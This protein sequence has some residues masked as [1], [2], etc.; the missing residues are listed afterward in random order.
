MQISND[1]GLSG[2]IVKK[3]F[4]GSGNEYKAGNVLTPADMGKILPEN[5]FHLV[6]AGYIELNDDRG[7]ALTS[8][9]QRLKDDNDSL[10]SENETLKETITNLEK[11]IEAL[12]GALHSKDEKPKQ[13]RGRNTKPKG[14]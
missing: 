11:E 3:S 1:Y 10:A 12:R 14:E 9:I 2:A 5:R 8:D 7:E 13:T 6:R 4:D